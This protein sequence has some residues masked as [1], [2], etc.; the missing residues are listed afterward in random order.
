MGEDHILRDAVSDEVVELERGGVEKPHTEQNRS[1]SR[2]LV[3][4]SLNKE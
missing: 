4:L 1:A 3:R 2:K